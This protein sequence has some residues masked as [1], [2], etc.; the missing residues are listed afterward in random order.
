MSFQWFK[1]YGGEYLS[2]PKIA[3]LTAQE[4][5]CWITLLSLAS[6]SSVSGFIEYL[7]VEVLLEKSG[8]KFDPYH[9]EEWDNSL[10]V[11]SKFERMKMIKRNENGTLEVLNWN[12]RQE[13]ALSVA[14]RV[15]KFRMKKTQKNDTA[16]HQDTK[17]NEV[18]NKKVVKSRLKKENVTDVTKCN[19]SDND[20]IEENRIDKINTDTNTAEQSPALIGKVIELFSELNPACKKMYGNKTQRK[21]C[22]DLVDTYSFE[23]VENCIVRVLPLTNGQPYFPTITTPL[24]LRDKWVALKSAVSK[25]RGNQVEMI[26]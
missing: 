4:R 15:R 6:I 16:L 3:S 8:I 20:R 9:P 22:Q 24:Q 10:S 13:S 2:D 7:T 12:K 17:S 25:K 1:F 21:A 23:E 19:E 11:L 18:Q 5:S 14:D 26:G